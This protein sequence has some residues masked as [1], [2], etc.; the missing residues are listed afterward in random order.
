MP[1]IS[2]LN[3]FF[4]R[5][6]PEMG[7]GSL[8]N[9]SE[10]VASHG[11]TLSVHSSVRSFNPSEL[12]RDEVEENGGVDSDDSLAPSQI[13]ARPRD[14]GRS[15]KRHWWSRSK[16]RKVHN[17][18]AHHHSRH[19]RPAD[20][21]AEEDDNNDSGVGANRDV[22]RLRNNFVNHPP[23]QP[24][25]SH[26]APRPAPVAR[27][28]TNTEATRR[29]PPP[30]GTSRGALPLQ[31]NRAPMRPGGYR[32]MPSGRAALGLPP[33]LPPPPRGSKRTM[34]FV[35][36]HTVLG[37]DPRRDIPYIRS[38]PWEALE[39]ASRA[40][41]PPRVQPSPRR[42]QMAA[43]PAGW[44]AYMSQ[45]NMAHQAP[46]QEN[47][48]VTGRGAGWA[49]S[50]SYR[51]QGQELQQDEYDYSDVEIDEEDT[52]ERELVDESPWWR[53]C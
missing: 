44:Q 11:R 38:P 53:C 15:P 22:R 34:T 27:P 24:K 33:M 52:D 28:Y 21:I 40:P 1:P 42:Q 19:H 4:P 10:G 18:A 50:G 46:A 37:L 32:P 9:P 5:M 29:R 2:R 31:T 47:R 45:R 48:Q 39:V 26:A 30:F 14:G 36:V 43:Y 41:P 16:G 12:Q 6:S 17:S 35:K 49:M 3:S 8:F 51:Q 25:P 7:N 13:R 23:T 20:G